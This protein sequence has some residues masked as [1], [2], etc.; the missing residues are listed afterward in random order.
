MS[1]QSTPGSPSPCCWLV[2]GIAP[3]PAPAAT[4]HFSYKTREGAI[5]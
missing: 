2:S 1:C 4:S 3:V 5:H